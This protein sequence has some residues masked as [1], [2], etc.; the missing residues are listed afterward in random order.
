MELLLLRRLLSM[1]IDIRQAVLADMEAKIAAGEAL[2]RSIAEQEAA[3][4]ALAEAEGA[5]AEARKIALQSGWT[6]AE[7]KRLKLVP[8]TR[9]ARRAP[10]PARSVA[11]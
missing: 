5:V 11:E 9:A 1:S 7:L 6:E 10:R 3:A 8:A 4:A 2:H